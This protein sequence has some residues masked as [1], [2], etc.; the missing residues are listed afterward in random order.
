MVLVL[1]SDLIKAPEHYAIP[2]NLSKS[3]NDVDLIG[4]GQP[5]VIN[6]R[7]F[8]NRIKNGFYIEAGAFDGEHLSNSLYYEIVHDWNG[9]L[10]EPNP[11]AYQDMLFKV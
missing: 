9:L 2:Y 6:N 1:K 10:V 5:L 8:K 11:D 3:I 7:I 4:G